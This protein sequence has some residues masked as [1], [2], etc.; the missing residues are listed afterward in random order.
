MRRLGRATALRAILV[1]RKPANPLLDALLK[2]ALALLDTAAEAAD[3]P[4][5]WNPGREVPIYAPH[6]VV[7]QAV[8]AASRHKKLAPFKG[9]VNG[10]LRRFLRE[11]PVI[12]TQ[13]LDDLE[14]KFNHPRWWVERLQ[15]AYPSQ[16]EALLG[17]ADE[18]GP[19]AL[20]VNARRASVDDVLDAFQGAGIDATSPMADAI[21]LTQPRPVHEL[22]GFQQGWW[23]VQDLSAQ[24]AGALL[25]IADGMRV[26]DAC[27]APGG[28]TAHLLE[29]ADLE[30]TALD[31]DPQRL[32]RVGEN[33]QRLGLLHDDVVLTAAD[34]ADTETW[35]DGVPYDAI[36]VDV[37]CTASGV[38]RRHP[39]IRWLR[40]EDDISRTAALQRRIVYA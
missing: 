19:M 32:A 15:Q 25:P 21:V 39:D 3:P 30:L 20:R 24:L 36:L 1:P 27:A 17:A 16:C 7:D 6:T 23:S 11:R 22:P 2:V 10:V 9:L 26:L 4:P 34:A 38:V 28:K 40:R 29:R 18:P 13:A 37:P 33:L 14:A 12:L 5:G 31:A 8:R 35:W